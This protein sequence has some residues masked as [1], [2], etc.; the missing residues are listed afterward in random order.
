M[1]D[2]R[3]ASTVEQALKILDDKIDTVGRV[4]RPANEVFRMTTTGNSGSWN[5]ATKVVTNLAGTYTAVKGLTYRANAT[6]TY[7][8]A[9]AANTDA[10]GIAFNQ[11]GAIVAGSTM[12]NPQ[13][14]R[15]HPDATGLNHG[16]ISARFT[17]TADGTVG[18]GVIGYKPTGDTGATNLF[19]NGTYA[20]NELWVEIVA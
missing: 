16:F 19:A 1:T 8:C 3:T 9:A 18:V 20:I 17:A 11:G 12:P 6:F 15:S 13:G 4:K 10:M 2:L 7:I 14:F 5:S